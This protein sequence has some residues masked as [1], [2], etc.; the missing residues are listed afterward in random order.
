MEL[1]KG[2]SSQSGEFDEMNYRLENK[3]N[4]VRIRKRIKCETCG[5][6]FLQRVREA[7]HCIHC[8]NGASF[9]R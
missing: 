9:S 3:K 8:G 5:K 7:R 4:V 1:S 6:F 2:K